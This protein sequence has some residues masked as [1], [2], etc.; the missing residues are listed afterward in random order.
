MKDIFSDETLDQIDGAIEK[1]MSERVFGVG[2]TIA[3]RYKVERVVGRGNFGYVYRALDTETGKKRAIKVFYARLVETEEAAQT[4]LQ[5]GQQLQQ[6][7]HPNIV[8]LFAAGA[9]GN[10]VYFAEEFISALTLDKLVDAVA[11]HAPDKGFPPDQINELFTQVCTALE[12][13]PKLPHLGLGP[14]N[15]FMSKTGVKIADH[16]QAGALRKFL[17]VKDMA[18]M[19]NKSFLAPEF[20]RDG[21]SAPTADVYSLGKLLAYVLTLQTSSTAQALRIRG[22]HPR[23]MLELALEAVSDDPDQRPPNAGAFVGAFEAARFAPLEEEPEEAALGL[24]EERLEQAADRV[25]S[26]VSEAVSARGGVE[27]PAGEEMPK[28][29]AEPISEEAEKEFFGEALEVEEAEAARAALEAPGELPSVEDGL[30]EL[31]DISDQEVVVPAEPQAEV[32]VPTVARPKKKAAK[33]PIAAVIIIALAAVLFVFRD[34]IFT[35]NPV[36]PTPVVDANHFDMEGMEIRP[37]PGG[38]TF[39]EMIQALLLQ[40][41]EYIDVNRL[42]DPPDD[43]AY[44]LFG[45]ILEMDEKNKAAQDGIEAIGKRYATL[46]RAFMNKKSYDRAT[47]A[48]RKVLVVDKNNREARDALAKIKRLAPQPTP[49]PPGE[50]PAELTPAVAST[51]PGPTGP[52]TNMTADAIRRTIGG[53]MGRI[54]FCFAKNPEASGVVKIRFVISPSGQVTSAN[55]AGSTL[56]NPEIES[57]LVRRVMVM[58]FPAFEGSPKTV[59]FPF[60]FNP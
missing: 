21:Q 33:W 51:T 11:K 14:R 49:L 22:R 37:E 16:G 25:V 35:Q 58:H 29:T 30:P 5:L 60:R 57:C 13:L 20:L 38:P 47:W 19:S 31:I 10:T 54:K 26:A 48:Y 34:S 59:T 41:Q 7:H 1:S 15:V 55:V 39:E 32:F 40:A 36:E 28:A 46:G 2:E 50:T 44:A 18:I 27:A 42:T 53:Y 23:R 8:R 4:L 9:E 6:L 24:E 43:C 52:L 45:L 3:G 17:D 56:A 12:K